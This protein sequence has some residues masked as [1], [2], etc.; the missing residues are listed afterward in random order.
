MLSIGA[1]SMGQEQYYTLL[2]REDYYLEGGEPPGMW[3]G[4]GAEALGLAGGLV[5]REH[6]T[7]LFRGWSPDGKDPL[8][9]M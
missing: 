6:L 9:K 8:V 5:N 3:L 1:M 7:N 4:H 2:A